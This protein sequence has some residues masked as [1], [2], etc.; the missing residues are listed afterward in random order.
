MGFLY[1]F[2][3][4][5]VLVVVW[6]VLIG[7]NDGQK[8]LVVFELVIVELVVEIEMVGLDDFG[9]LM[10]LVDIVFMVYEI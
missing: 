3:V 7:Q 10:F 5:I 4:N 8:V 2:I 6:V 1:V 9:I